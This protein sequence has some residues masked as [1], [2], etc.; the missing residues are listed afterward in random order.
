M[1]NFSFIKETDDG[2][3]SGVFSDRVGTVVHV[4]VNGIKLVKYVVK[5][6]SNSKD[7]VQLKAEDITCSAEKDELKKEIH[8]LRQE[9]DNL[10]L[11]LTESKY[12]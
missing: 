1:S 3:I 10:K 11:L 4:G 7:V 2:V 8:L 9:V 12:L 5:D 6:D